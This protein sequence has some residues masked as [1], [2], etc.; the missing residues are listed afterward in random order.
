MYNTLVFTKPFLNP[1]SGFARWP[2][3]MDCMLTWMADS[4]APLLLLP[5]SRPASTSRPQ[6]PGNRRSSSFKISCSVCAQ[7][8][9]NQQ[10][11]KDLA[12]LPLPV[13]RS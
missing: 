7:L 1:F 10:D 3:E 9:F 5:F 13:S 2:A 12:A 11:A 6:P 8:S 4:W